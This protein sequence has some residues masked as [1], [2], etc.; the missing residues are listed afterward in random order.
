MTLQEHGEPLR[1]AIVAVN[2]EQQLVQVEAVVTVDTLKDLA[3]N[4][5][6]F[7]V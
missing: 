6:Q 1:W 7:S 5:P 4:R 3:A 2:S